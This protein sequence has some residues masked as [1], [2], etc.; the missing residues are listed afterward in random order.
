MPGE[1]NVG[2]RLKEKYQEEIITALREEFGY[3]NIMQVP[4]L[5]KI[6]V[7]MGVGD[8]I[9]DAKLMDTAVAELALITGQ[10]PVIRKAHKSIS[11]FK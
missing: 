10:K 5:E 8:A 9:A 7:N 3:T 1:F 4:G 11:N 2:I 6:V